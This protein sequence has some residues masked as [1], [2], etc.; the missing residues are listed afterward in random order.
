MTGDENNCCDGFTESVP[1]PKQTDKAN[2]KLLTGG[3]LRKSPSA[4]A[5]FQIEWAKE[6]KRPGGRSIA[7]PISSGCRALKP[8]PEDLKMQGTLNNLVSWAGE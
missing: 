3:R 8:Q 2:C 6:L 4:K 5:P 1:I 7:E